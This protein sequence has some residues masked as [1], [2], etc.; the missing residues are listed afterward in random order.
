MLDHEFLRAADVSP[1]IMSDVYDSSE[2]KKFMG[3]VIYPNN[4]IGLYYAS[5]VCVVI[6]YYYHNHLLFSHIN[7]IGMCLFCRFASLH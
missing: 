2:W 1:D 6:I 4:R 3:A 7:G 5:A